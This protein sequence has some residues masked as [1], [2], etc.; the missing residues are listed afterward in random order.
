MKLVMSMLKRQT[1]TK[2]DRLNWEQLVGFGVVALVLWVIVGNSTAARTAGLT[3][4]NAL[5]DAITNLI[6]DIGSFV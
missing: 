3:I 1:G 6:T 2:E 5:R 4:L